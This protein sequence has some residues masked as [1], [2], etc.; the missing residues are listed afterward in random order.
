MLIKS[1]ADACCRLGDCVT[2]SGP[3]WQ[4]V[5]QRG[6]GPVLALLK[7]RDTGKVILAGMPIVCWIRLTC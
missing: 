5:Q 4:Q 2:G 7:H 1:P 6:E 3:F